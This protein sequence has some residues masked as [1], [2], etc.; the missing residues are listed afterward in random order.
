MTEVLVVPTGTANL[1]SVLAGLRRAG[2]VPRVCEEPGPIERA[3][4]VVLPGVGTFRAAVT[5]LQALGV[6]EALRTRLAADRPVLAVCVGLQVLCGRSEESPGVDGLGALDAEVA[7]FGPG[8][9]RP[10]MGWNRVRPQPA[11]RLLQPG[12]A[13]FANGYRLGAAPRDCAV[14]WSAH[15]GP[16]IAAVERGGLTACQFHPEL[17]GAW[18]LDLLERWVAQC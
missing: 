4:G 5:R 18:G 2:A 16:F 6:V 11:C 1:A 3:A 14:A 17:S 12:W 8:V 7:A 10:Q 9:R 13:Y 15:G